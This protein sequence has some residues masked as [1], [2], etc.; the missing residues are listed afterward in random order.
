MI[1]NFWKKHKGGIIFILFILQITFFYKLIQIY[2]QNGIFLNTTL[3]NKIPFL[4]TFV[5]F[6]LLFFVLLFLPFILNFKDK[7]K[8][9]ALSATFFF[10][11]IICNLF[12]VFFQT[13]VIRP[14]I[15]V[16][17]IFDKLVLFIYSIDK[18]LNCFPSMHVTFSALS[19]LCLLKL[20]K[21]AGQIIL[22]LAIL[23]VFSTLLI[24]QHVILDVIG[25]LVLA[26]L[27]YYF[28][29]RKMI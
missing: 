6:Y 28:I 18:S 15:I 13:T 10:V 25:G 2:S 4:S 29:F 5:I 20:N 9:L 24:K 19:T 17:T 12:Y 7:K 16:S 21:K 26:L 3:D 11:S 23:I 27:G 8:F 14:E 1:K 22:P